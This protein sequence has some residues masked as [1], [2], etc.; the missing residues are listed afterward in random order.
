MRAGDIILA[1]LPQ[2]DGQ[3]KNRPA[4]ILAVL[5][6]FGDVL[7][8]GLSTQLQHEV[9]GFDELIVPSDPDFFDTGLQAA[10]L[11]RVGF[12]S[13]LPCSAIKGRMG[14]LSLARRQ[15]VTRRLCAQLGGFEGVWP[16]FVS[17]WF[18]NAGRTEFIHSSR[19]QIFELGVAETQ[20][21]YFAAQTGCK[22]G[23]I[24]PVAG[25]TLLSARSLLS[26]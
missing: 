17:Y 8:C 3:T 5:K 14:R 6:P 9:P 21:H 23:K 11:L 1:P 22:T 2:A 26:D 24:R 13:T 15:R 19:E 7:L 25:Q 16:F 4:L 10:S 12:L 20:R 18:K